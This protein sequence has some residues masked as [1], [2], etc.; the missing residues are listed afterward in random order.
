MVCICVS[1]MSKGGVVG[2]SCWFHPSVRPSAVVDP[3]DK[4]LWVKGER[5]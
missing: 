3:G 4:L 2:K 5:G 1:V